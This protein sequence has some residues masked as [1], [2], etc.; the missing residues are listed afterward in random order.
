MIMTNSNAFIAAVGSAFWLFLA[1]A[2]PMPPDTGGRVLRAIYF[3]GSWLWAL[4]AI[5]QSI[6]ELK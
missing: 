3:A 5:I 2:V 1:L 4:V 6:R